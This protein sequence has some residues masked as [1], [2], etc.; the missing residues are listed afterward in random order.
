[1]YN[2]IGAEDDILKINQ[3]MFEISLAADEVLDDAVPTATRYRSTSSVKFDRRVWRR[4][5]SRQSATTSYSSKPAVA[6][7]KQLLL[8]S[9]PSA[10]LIY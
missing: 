3:S 1:M 4:F 9:A 5:D 8:S 10:K 6:A 7:A 2:V